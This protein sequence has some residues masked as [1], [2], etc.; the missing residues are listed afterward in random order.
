MKL[1]VSGFKSISRVENFDFRKLT[2]L[3]GINSSGK[4]SLIQALLLL[5][6]TFESNSI[7]VLNFTGD[8]INVNEPLNLIHNKDKNKRLHYVLSLKKEEIKNLDSYSLYIPDGELL[9]E[10]DIML[11]FSINK[12]FKLDCLQLD[13]WYGKEGRKECFRVYSPSTKDTHSVTFSKSTM[14]NNNGIKDKNIST[15]YALSY[16]YGFLP[17]YGERKDEFISLTIIKDLSD[18]LESLFKKIDYIGPQRVKPVLARTYSKL[19]YKNVGNDGEYTRF[20]INEHKDEIVEGYDDKL[21]SL[22]T[23]WVVKRMHLAQEIDV[24]RDTNKR[25]RVIV[26]NESNVKV[27]LDQTG[28]GLSQILPIITQG[29][30][31]PIGGT[32]VVEDPD[33]HMHPSVQAELV[34]FF[35]DLIAHGR[36]VIIETHSDHIVTR[37]R[38][39]LAKHENIHSKDVNVCFVSNQE[40]HSEYLSCALTEKGAFSE[41]LPTGFMDSQENDFKNIIHL[42]MINS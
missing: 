2:L 18:T 42:Q 13:L 5:K 23:Y 11:D 14:V 20:L 35:A 27:D 25:Y 39:L 24:V 7:E 31:T 12:F 8:F 10:L 29:L 37:M 26:R 30:L 22:I 34:N 38:L 4:S 32:L 21:L 40:G 28:F 3:A 15:G 36:K 17:F 9:K 33:A 19:S 6:Q 16:K 41:P 1:T